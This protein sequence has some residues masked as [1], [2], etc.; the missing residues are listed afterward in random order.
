MSWR[1]RQVWIVWRSER[2]KVIVFDAYIGALEAAA[3]RGCSIK[4]REAVPFALSGVHGFC[5]PPAL[6]L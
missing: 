6:A 4:V 5:Q 2:R 1:N 3:G